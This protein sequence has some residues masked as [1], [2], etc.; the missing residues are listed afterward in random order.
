VVHRASSSIAA[1]AWSTSPA[2][3]TASHQSSAV[4][5]PQ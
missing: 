4:A 2:E 5:R 3:S 1:A